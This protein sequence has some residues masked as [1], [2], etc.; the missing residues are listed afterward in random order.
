MIGQYCH[1]NQP[2]HEAPFSYHFIGKPEKSQK[3]IDNILNNLYGIG[4]Q[5]LALCGMDDAGELSSWYVFTALG[6]YPFSATDA[7]YI[8]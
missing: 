2:D 7:E 4:E 1:G 8:V 6:L 3:I 5:G